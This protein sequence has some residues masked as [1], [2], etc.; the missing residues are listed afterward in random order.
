MLLQIL[1]DGRLTDGKGRAIDFSNTIVI[2]TSNIGAEKLQKEAQLGFQV[3]TKK[4]QSDLDSLHDRNKSAVLDALKKT[5][6][7]ELINRIDNMIVFRALTRPE[8]VRIL[9][10]QIADLERRLIP[11]GLGLRV[12]P[13]AK[14]YLADAGYDAKN[15]VRPLRRLIQDTLE[16][17]ISTGLLDGTYDKGDHVLVGMK[18]GELSY[19][20]VRE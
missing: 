14:K 13:A 12:L 19:S 2:M 7:P 3:K 8:I 1:E 9:D 10:L 20:A 4:D 17:N 18:Q 5:M 11:Q 16:D 15:G 6:R